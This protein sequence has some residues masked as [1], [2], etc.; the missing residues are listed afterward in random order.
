MKKNIAIVVLCLIAIGAIASTMNPT[1]GPT[2]APP[3]ATTAAVLPTDTPIEAPEPTFVE[4]TIDQAVGEFGD[5]AQ[6]SLDQTHEAVSLLQ[7]I[8]AAANA[9]DIIGIQGG[10]DKLL[11]WSRKELTWLDSNPPADCFAELHAAWGTAVRAFGEAGRLASAWVDDVTD[12]DAA[13]AAIKAM[14]R[15]NTKMTE[16]TTAIDTVSC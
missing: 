11:A 9:S 14:N 4:P 16:A 5:F 6:H 15:A 13:D 2:P 3:A 12:A 8:E 7:D 10:A 1:P